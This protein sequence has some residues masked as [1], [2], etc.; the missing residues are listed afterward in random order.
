MS[1]H[2]LV[3][4]EG[5]SADD[6]QWSIEHPPDC[7]QEKQKTPFGEYFDYLC[8]VQFCIDHVGIEDIE[9]WETL[10]PGR[11]PIGFY[12]HWSGSMFDDSEAYIYL[13]SNDK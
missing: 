2:T 11:Y 13:V 5:H 3:I 7:P 8:N 6:P 10:P 4:E 1:E 9:G 12:S